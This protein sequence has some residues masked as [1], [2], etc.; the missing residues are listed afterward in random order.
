MKMISN[1]NID[2]CASLQT[3]SHST[4]RNTLQ[5]EIVVFR[6][7]GIEKGFGRCSSYYDF[8]IKVFYHYQK[9]FE[10]L[11]AFHDFGWGG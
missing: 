8:G 3:D 6:S 10:K 7:L 2:I 1:S 5:R 9:T 11:H 4:S